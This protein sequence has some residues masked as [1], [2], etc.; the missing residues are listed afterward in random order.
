[1]KEP[2]EEPWNEKLLELK[3]RRGGALFRKHTTLNC[4]VCAPEGRWAGANGVYKF[5]TVGEISGG[6]LY[7][8]LMGILG[9][10]HG[11]LVGMPLFLVVRPTLVA[12]EGKPITVHVVHVELR[13]P[14]MRAIQDQARTVM[15]YELEH[16]DRIR[17]IDTQ[18][19]ALIAPPPSPAEQA[20]IN[21]EFQ[22]QT[23]TEHVEA[24]PEGEDELLKKNGPFE[25]DGGKRRGAE[26]GPS[27]AT[28][29]VTGP[30]AHSAPPAPAP[31]RASS[32]T[33]AE[34]P[35]DPD[36]PLHG[37]K[38]RDADA[39]KPPPAEAGPL[40]VE[41]MKALR[42]ILKLRDLALWKAWLRSHKFPEKVMAADARAV[43][44]E[45]EKAVKAQ[46]AAAGKPAKPEAPMPKCPKCK[47]DTWV[48]A[49][50]KAGEFI[51]RECKKEFKA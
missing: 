13:A 9:L 49:L 34:P 23:A 4:V 48:E 46:R 22:P 3:D 44:A 42:V 45:L 10:T 18:Y 31:G 21:Q 14:N 29:P 5:R 24:P 8:T 17:I 43:I 40:E 26:A 30:V 6:Q 35:A 36:D 19:K 51:C 11:V 25:S 50:G 2:I 47:D 32:R 39:P 33:P 28:A 1:L 20:D 37:T 16:K 12:P 41:T 38:P 15:E 7:S 27:G